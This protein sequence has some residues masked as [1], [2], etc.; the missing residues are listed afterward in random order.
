MLKT[1]RLLDDTFQVLDPSSDWSVIDG[2]NTPT[3]PDFASAT[4]PVSA[5]TV[6]ASVLKMTL[7]L[8]ETGNANPI[9]YTDINQGQIGDC[10]LLS[11]IGE[12][13]M[14]KPSFISNMIH[15]NAN[16]T[17]TITLYEGSNGLAADYGTTKYKAVT[18]VVS[19]VFQSNGVNNGASQDVMASQ[20][21]IWPQVIEKADAQLNGGPGLSSIANG[22]SPV[23]A[24]EQ[25]TGHAAQWVD[26]ANLTLA[27]LITFVN[28]ADLLVFDTR[29]SGALP[30]GLVNNH[31]YMFDGITGSGAN[32]LVHFANP[33]GIDNPSPVAITQ[34]SRGFAEVD[35]GHLS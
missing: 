8:T 31:A 35:I 30:S 3:G 19:N 17:E 25:L 26:P 27:N 21:E 34:L 6:T 4:A 16:G 11:S 22:G 33:W 9:S 7:Y 20:K 32:A 2:G 29:A 15:L 5:A 24:L 28:S 14:Q 1:H 10:F 13:A 23:I 12:I 18:E